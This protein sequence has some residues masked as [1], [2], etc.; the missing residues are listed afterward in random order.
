MLNHVCL[1]GDSRGD[2]GAVYDSAGVAWADFDLGAEYNVVDS[3][4]LSFVHQ[5]FC[6]TLKSVLLLV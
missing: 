1:P 2:D 5:S 3:S 4:A 6:G